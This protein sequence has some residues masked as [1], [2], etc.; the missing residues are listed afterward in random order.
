VLCIGRLWFVVLY[1]PD[2]FTASDCKVSA[3]LS[4]V[5]LDASLTCHFVDAAFV[6]VVFRVLVLFC[7]AF[8]FYMLTW[9][10]C[11]LIGL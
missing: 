4:Y 8:V 11:L 6:K 5:C 7:T 2:V 9:C 1:V 10:L 3:G